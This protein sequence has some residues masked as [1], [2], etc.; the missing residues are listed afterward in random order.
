MIVAEPNWLDLLRARVN[1]L[2]TIQAVARELDYSR[3]AISLALSGKY[4]GSVTH[5]E[6]T[7]IAAY[8]TCG[9]PHLRRTITAIECRKYRCRPIPQ[10]RPEELR[11]WTAC[12]SCPIGRRM[13]LAEELRRKQAC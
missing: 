10:S 5:L 1:E 6:A 12:Q 4:P 11:H 2:G 3:A 7:V 9:C 13:A 8:G